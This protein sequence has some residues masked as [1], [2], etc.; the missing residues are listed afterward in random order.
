MTTTRLSLLA[1]AAVAALVLAGC[2][3]APQGP[4]DSNGGATAADGGTTGPIDDNVD[5]DCPRGGS[6]TNINQAG[7][8]TVLPI[9]EAWAEDFG[10]CLKA[11]IV[12][13]GGGT[14]AG[15]QK[16]CRGE[17]DIADA[18]R[19]IRPAS[20]AGTSETD[21]CLKAGI[22]PFELQVAID[23][24]SVVVSKS[25]T[26]VECL[27]V[28]QLHSIY[29]ASQ[30]KQVSNWKDLDPAWPDQ[31]INIFG[32]G[33]DSGTYDYFREVIIAPT[34]GSTAST[35]SDFTPSED[36]NVLVQGIASSEYAIGYFGLAYYDH[37][38]DKLNLVDI[39]EGKGKGCVE[40]TPAS[41]VSGDYSPLS[42]PIFM[43]TD[44]KPDGVLKSYFEQGFSATGQ[45]LVEEVGYIK[46]G[47]AKLAEMKA[48]IA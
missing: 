17:L 42:R 33:T 29:T 34:D 46:L 28:A 12:V 15:F 2:S 27:T 40:A 1:M 16:F 11:N 3:S 6:F 10:P 22:E 24:L 44:G 48:K 9:A 13:G 8:S 31:K 25:N 18:S 5:V 39:D 4:E 23:G 43:Y 41:V 20:P 47:P 32:P 30:S 26:F 38:K 21:I 45:G 19:P 37:N 14:G 35:R 36:D 7:S